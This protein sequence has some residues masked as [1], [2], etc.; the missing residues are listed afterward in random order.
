MKGN[1]DT[2]KSTRISQLE[3]LLVEHKKEMVELKETNERLKAA[4]A[5]KAVGPPADRVA[6]PETPSRRGATLDKTLAEQIRRNEEL[7]TSECGLC[8]LCNMFY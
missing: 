5:E 4:V 1:F 6:P 2:Q 7:Q 3:G 8:R